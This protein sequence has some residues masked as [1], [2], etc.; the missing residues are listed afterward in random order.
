MVKSAQLLEFSAW[1]LPDPESVHATLAE[2]I[3]R[4]QVWLELYGKSH[5]GDRAIAENLLTQ[6]Q[7]FVPKADVNIPGPSKPYELTYLERQRLELARQI[8]DSVSTSSD[9]SIDTLTPTSSMTSTIFKGNNA[10]GKNKQI[11]EEEQESPPDTDLSVGDAMDIDQISDISTLTDKSSE[12]P[13]FPAA[14]TPPSSKI[15]R[16]GKNLVTSASTSMSRGVRRSGATGF[17]EEMIEPQALSKK[18]KQSSSAIPFHLRATTLSVSRSINQTPSPASTCLTISPIEPKALS[19]SS[20]GLAIDTIRHQASFLPSTRFS[21][22]PIQREAA[23]EAMNLDVLSKGAIKRLEE[24]LRWRL[25]NQSYS[26]KHIPQS[27]LSFPQSR[28]SNQIVVTAATL[29]EASRLVDHD[30]GSSLLAEFI[31][32]YHLAVFAIHY[33]YRKKAL[34]ECY[35]LN[36]HPSKGRPTAVNDALLKETVFSSYGA[37]MRHS[38]RGAV[39]AG[40]MERFGYSFLALVDLDAPKRQ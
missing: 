24:L 12:V 13:I 5:L 35:R 25:K 34:E 19:P 23:F 14:P 32:R 22:D 8:N 11:V 37:M 2:G 16:E 33:G 3:D 31:R 9:S 6:I 15:Q 4:F 18:R 1:D 7:D 20:S 21:V 26:I 28:P 40:L 38:Y 30:L 39:W 10:K 17:E 29:K 36:P 27:K